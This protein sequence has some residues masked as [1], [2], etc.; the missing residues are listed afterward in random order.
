[1]AFKFNALS[2]GDVE[3]SLTGV[4]GGNIWTDDPNPCTASRVRGE[5]AKNPNA[6]QINC[7]V[8]SDGGDVWEGL[9]IYQALLE[10]PARV[11]VTIGARAISC[12]SLI[13]MAGDEISM[14]ETSKMLIHNPWTIAM[15]DAEDF[16]ARAKDLRNLEESF[17]SAYAA[18]TGMSDVAVRELMNEDRLMG[19]EEAKEKGFCTDVRK[20]PKKP[21][22]M[23][24]EEIR[25]EVTR[26]R[27]RAQASVS[28]LRIAAMSP[29]QTITEPPAPTAPEA[30]SSKEKTMNIALIV[31]ALG[32]SEGASE[33]DV[34]NA[35]SGLKSAKETLAKCEAKL[36]ASG[37]E[38]VISVGVL[39][40]KSEV[41]ASTRSE[42][43]ALKAKIE[44]DRVAA[45]ATEKDRIVAQLVSEGKAVGEEMTT[46]L[47]AKS[48]DDL[49]MHAKF[50]K[51]VIP[52]TPEATVREND[53]TALALTD[54]EKTE[55][56]E[57]SMTDTEYL[58]S[59]REV[60]AKYGA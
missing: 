51:P 7:L 23:S 6:K 48:L 1:M 15:G 4:I 21:K 32:L 5:L 24:E 38:I 43:E 22:A 18:R 54:R 50:A 36:G 60:Q 11:S 19:A 26:M 39:K 35:I 13:A 34:L 14:H 46:W 17:A 58:A 9:G 57:L 45:E 30:N 12:G 28:A 8:D 25:S 40:D 16:E 56:R 47:N 27:T 3:I 29:Q 10:H 2:N 42:L 59:K 52:G 37:N 44:A 33:T 49:R 53:P 20:S 55:A 41:L 31:A